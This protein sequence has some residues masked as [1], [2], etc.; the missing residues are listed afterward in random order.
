[1][2]KLQPRQNQ[3]TML[4]PIHVPDIYKSDSLSCYSGA[5][6]DLELLWNTSQC[7]ISMWNDPESLAD[8]KYKNM[9][10][11]YRRL[12]SG[13]YQ[14]VLYTSLSFFMSKILHKKQ[15]KS[16]VS[17]HQWNLSSLRKTLVKKFFQKLYHVTKS[18]LA[19]YGGD[20]LIQQFPDFYKDNEIG[21]TII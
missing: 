2:S 11:K 5:P 7:G 1:M 21:D 3:K 12:L 6:Q 13:N 16:R 9:K 18:T 4:T 10:E 19:L 15:G 20:H 8:I 14:I 17:Y